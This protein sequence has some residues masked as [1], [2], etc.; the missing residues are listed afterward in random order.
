MSIPDRKDESVRVAKFA[1]WHCWKN[2]C[3]R[4]ESPLPLTDGK[5][6]SLIQLQCAPCVAAIACPGTA[7]E[8]HGERDERLGRGNEQHSRRRPDDRYLV[9]GRQREFSG[10]VEQHGL[11]ELRL[12]EFAGRLLQPDHYGGGA[13]ANVGDGRP[14]LRALAGLTQDEAARSPNI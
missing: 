3:I 10:A 14:G 13:E 6:E 9:V 2:V 11:A 4:I 12:A 1:L 7:P 5:S 8:E